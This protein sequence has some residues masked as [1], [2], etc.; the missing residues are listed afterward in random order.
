MKIHHFVVFR[1]AGTQL[2]KDH[3]EYDGALVMYEVSLNLKG[4]LRAAAQNIFKHQFQF[5]KDWNI[6]SRESAWLSLQEIEYSNKKTIN[7]TKHIVV[8]IS[9]GKVN[10]IICLFCHLTLII[11][12]LMSAV[13]GN[14]FFTLRL[15]WFGSG[16]FHCWCFLFKCGRRTNCAICKYSENVSFYTCPFTGAE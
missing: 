7:E 14:V 2:G 4:D 12:D 13:M 5:P 11:I 8:S 6:R 1:V 15:V 9:F 3:Y 10:L 16:N